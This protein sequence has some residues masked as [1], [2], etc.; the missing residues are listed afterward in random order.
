[1]PSTKH[2]FRSIV[3]LSGIALISTAALAGCS[4]VQSAAPSGKSAEPVTMQLCDGSKVTFDNTPDKIATGNTSALELLIR[5]GA[6]DKVVGTAWSAGAKTL[7]QDVREKAEK[8]PSLGE[9]AADKE[10]LLKSGAQVYIDPYESM[11]MMGITGPT[12]EDF[13]AAGMKRVMLR[14]SACN[15]TLTGPVTTLDGVKEDIRSLAALVGRKQA[16]DELVE[17]M[18][19]DPAP[20][21]AEKPKILYLIGA[22]NNDRASTIG[23]R[24]IGNAIIEL[25]GGRN[26]FESVDKA[27]FAGSWEDVV[28][29][30]PDAIVLTVT[31]Q[32]TQEAADKAYRALVDQ[33]RNDPRTAA[34]RA[35]RDQKFV[36][37]YAEDMTLPGV[38][39]A[40]MV[41]T[42]AQEISKLK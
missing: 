12:P 13:A 8:V 4:S 20:A 21:K 1:M 25:A 32:A 14:S 40:Q 38:E 6:A 31:R 18:K 10:K 17:S 35:V 42:L 37:A 22:R 15:D 2:S 27:Q 26:A 5:L 16:G 19:V 29:S 33:L 28:A 39:N 7:P 9:R 24:Q 11:P 30:D 36:R 41:R 23:N 34:M 3:R